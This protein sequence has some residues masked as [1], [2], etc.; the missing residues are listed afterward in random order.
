[1]ESDRVRGGFVARA[2][3]D[4][5]E[6]ASKTIDIIK[7]GGVAAVGATVPLAALGSALLAPPPSS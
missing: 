6:L 2:V 3:E 4:H 7:R 5:V 1:V